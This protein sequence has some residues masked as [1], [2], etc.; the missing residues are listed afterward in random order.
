M[1]FLATL[2]EKRRFSVF[3][4]AKDVGFTA[5]IRREGRMTVPKEV[6]DALGI[7]EGDLVECWIRKVR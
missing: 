1:L 6:R 5:Y 3:I 4:M 2:I 7:K